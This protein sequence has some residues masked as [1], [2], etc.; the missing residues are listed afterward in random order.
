MRWTAFVR[1]SS[2]YLPH[3]PSSTTQF[4]AHSLPRIY[5]PPPPNNCSLPSSPAH[6]YIVSFLSRLTASPPASA[7][8]LVKQ[9]SAAPSRQFLFPSL[10]LHLPRRCPLRLHPLNPG[11][12]AGCDGARQL[13]GN[14]HVCE[15]DR[16]YR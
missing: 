3:L 9:F 12:K 11:S 10:R 16:C 1:V 5:P 7:E 6:N 2:A 14:R 15:Y 4:P 8:A 13:V